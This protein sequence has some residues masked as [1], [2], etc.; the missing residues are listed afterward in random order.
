MKKNQIRV[1]EAFAGYG[2][3]A[4]ALKKAK[5]DFKAIGY[6]E[7]DKHACAL[8]EANHPDVLNYGDITEIDPDNLP[9]F[10]LFTGGFPCQPFSQVGLGQGELDIR[11]TLFYD[12]I[13]ICETKKPKHILLENVKGLKTN[14]HGKTLE[15]IIKRL[16]NLGYDIVVE[17]LNSKDYGIPQ[18]RDRVWIYGYHGSLPLEFHLPPPKEKLKVFLHDILD[19]NPDPKLFKSQDQI[20]R[21]KELY[22]IDFIVDK[23]SCADLYNK[24]IRKDGI[25]ITILEPHHNKMRIVHPPIN[26][27]LL[28]RN[29][30]VSEHFRLM[31]FKDGEINF[32]NQSYQQL[33]KRAANGW[34]INLASKIFTQI[35]NQLEKIN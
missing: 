9:D 30:S 19:K 6:S 28:V 1:F 12:I 8:Y 29:Y 5:I 35:F 18:N 24:N 27:E 4:F 11:G 33:C 14:R 17:L 21:L 3:A 34:D 31:G 16:N 32:I 10:D 26:D 7:I 2:G 25:S 23:P 20:K 15:T 22:G 13:R